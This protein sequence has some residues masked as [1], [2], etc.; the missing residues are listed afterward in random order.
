VVGR[1]FEDLSI[2]WVDEFGSP[3]DDDASAV[4]A[5]GKGVYVVGSTLG[6]LPEGGLIGE[7]DGFLLKFLPKGAEVWTRQL[8]TDDYDRVYGMAADGK[9]V[10]VVGTTHGVVAGDA[11]AGDRDVFAIRVAFS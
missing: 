8:G 5:I 2:A 6:S 1:L 10:V 11:N 7:T 3:A 9:G 4:S